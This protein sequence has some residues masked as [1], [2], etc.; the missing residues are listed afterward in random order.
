MPELGPY[1]S[2]RGALSNERPYRD[3][4]Q[5]PERLAACLFERRTAHFGQPLRDSNALRLGLRRSQVRRR[6]FSTG[7][8]KE[9]SP[10]RLVAG[11]S[12]AGGN[13]VPA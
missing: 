10:T 5:N 7:C 11:R 12:G 3:C 2:V 4:A 1:G 13:A 9:A 8:G 6:A